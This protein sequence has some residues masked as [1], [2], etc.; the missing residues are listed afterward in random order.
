MA[1]YPGFSIQCSNIMKLFF[2]AAIS[3]DI[4]DGDFLNSF[5]ALDFSGLLRCAMLLQS[6]DHI[7]DLLP[8]ISMSLNTYLDQGEMTKRTNFSFYASIFYTRLSLSCEPRRSLISD[9]PEVME[10]LPVI[11]RY[12]ELRGA[13]DRDLGERLDMSEIGKEWW[14]ES[15]RKSDSV[16]IEEDKTKDAAQRLLG[17]VLVLII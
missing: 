13:P 12:K 3:P 7:D 17:I 6:K 15:L 5:H 2:Q 11:Q 9:G 4:S 1:Y 16:C 10:A 8:M 14:W